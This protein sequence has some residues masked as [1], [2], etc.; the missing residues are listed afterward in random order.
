MIDRISERDIEVIQRELKVKEE[1]AKQVLEEGKQNLEARVAL[2]YVSGK[3]LLFESVAI[4][5]VQRSPEQVISDLKSKVK[6]S[7]NSLQAKLIDI[8]RRTKTSSINDW[9]MDIRQ[10]IEE[11]DLQMIVSW[12]SLLG[13]R[14]MQE[15]LGI[16]NRDS[17]GVLPETESSKEARKHVQNAVIKVLGEAISLGR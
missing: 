11:L 5:G 9:P 10:S 3:K 8:V 2:A 4:K 16:K 13:A 1:R 15:R 7:E 14:K 12:A 6:D 17:N